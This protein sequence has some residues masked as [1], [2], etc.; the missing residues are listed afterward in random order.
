MTEC[1]KVSRRFPWVTPFASPTP[2]DDTTSQRS[3]IGNSRLLYPILLYKADEKRKK[4][5]FHWCLYVERKRRLWYHCLFGQEHNN[6]G[7]TYLKF[8]EYIHRVDFNYSFVH[9]YLERSI[10]WL[11]FSLSFPLS[12]DLSGA[13]LISRANISKICIRICKI[14]STNKYTLMIDFWYFRVSSL[15]N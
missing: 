9:Y 15:V 10:S 12:L 11:L 8:E 14:R 6:F 7:N 3:M 5:R 2:D 4:P 13:H 1:N